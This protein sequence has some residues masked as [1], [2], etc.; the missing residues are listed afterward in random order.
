MVNL[1]SR[2]RGLAATLLMLLAGAA[3]AADRGM[4]IV[5]T[6][7]PMPDG[8]SLA[9][10][11]YLPGDLKPA[12]RV[13]A[14][15]EYLPYRKDD[16]TLPGDYGIHS[17]F[18]QHGY[19]GVR[20]DIRGFGASGGATPD[21]EYSA[22]EQAD[23]E[24]V[25]AWLARQPWSNGRV[26]MFGISWG[27]FN[28]IQLAMRRPPALKAILAIEAT[29]ALFTE[30]VHYID[31]ILH[32]DEWELPMDLDEGR[33]G[34]PNFP[35]D[36][37]T[38]KLRMDAPPWTLNY[39][40]HQ[41]DGEFWR[42]PVRRLEDI[43]IPCFLIA[44]LQ[45]GYRDS[46]LRMLE[47]VPAPVYA[48]LGP[49]NHD[50]PNTSMY[51]PRVEW[52]DRAVRWFDHWLKDVDNGVEND[53]RLIV[54][55]QHSHPPGAAAQDI[56][57]EWRSEN[58]PPQG[59]RSATWFLAPNHGLAPAVAAAAVDRLRYVP[60][61]GVEA[62]FWW[63]ELLGDQRPVDA[64]SLTYDSVPLESEVYLLGRPQV[65]LVASA[66]APLANWFVRLEDVAED[67]RVTAITGAALSGAQRRSSEHPEPLVPGQE[68]V[69]DVALHLSSWV[70]PKGHRI[71]LA[72][73]NA[74]WPMTWP[75]PYA[76]TTTLRLGGPAGSL[77]VLPLVP[78]RAP[79]AAAFE[80]PGPMEAAPG[81]T[82]GD[83]AW[84]G[85]FTVERDQANGRSTV[86]WRG[87]SA[88]QYP[89]G[90]HAHHEKVVYTVADEHPEASSVDGET[91][92]EEKLPGYVLT[93]RGHLQLRSDA[94]TFHYDYTRTLL[95]DGTVVRTRHWQE[96]IPRD[97]Q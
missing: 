55:Q 47:R 97:L 6:S 41:R 15:L 79:A 46:I 31:G 8:V 29:E 84:P 28:S 48:W 54:Y 59:Q 42:A 40:R 86:T 67:G 38:L 14:L 64:F 83:A 71:R 1:G 58:W 78:A 33:S 13:P 81:V 19:A 2:C 32:F 16:D 75:T 74:L 66:D 60:S 89:W 10:T 21:R 70:W 90:S 57:G 34:A 11:L 24:R 43:H 23:A 77:L 39:F 68:Y 80:A 17:Y 44:G 35:I 25:I 12:E 53:P 85:S 82:A 76:M 69:F 96:E 51:G 62:G 72:V 63:G 7:I 65:R 50:E 27:G 93:W 3:F 30:D 52:R 45:D 94:T 87:Q 22:Q 5:K 73:S 20:V 18:A 36:E 37:E 26:G 9:A 95:R 61:T 56:P 91:D 4:H 88:T 49:W 92:T